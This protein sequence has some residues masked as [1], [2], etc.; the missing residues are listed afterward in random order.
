[1]KAKSRWRGEWGNCEGKGD[2]RRLG[3]NCEGEGGAE[4]GNQLKEG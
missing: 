1:V 2:G 4:V 3:D